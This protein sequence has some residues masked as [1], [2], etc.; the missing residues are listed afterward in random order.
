MSDQ[1]SR[2]ELARSLRRCLG[3]SRRLEIEKDKFSSRLR[4]DCI[5]QRP[6]YHTSSTSRVS[7][8]TSLLHCM[9]DPDQNHEFVYNDQGQVDINKLPFFDLNLEINQTVEDYVERII[10]TLAAAIN[11]QLPPV[12]WQIVSK[13]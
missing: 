6:P 1:K 4:I 3:S 13:P 9:A 12:Q 8:S 7:W 2:R 10:Y 11:E 5:F